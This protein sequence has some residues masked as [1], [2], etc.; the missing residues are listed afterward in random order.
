M[1]ADGMSLVLTLDL[2]KKPVAPQ[3]EE[4]KDDDV[5]VEGEGS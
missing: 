2:E 5:E 4:N 1:A 3:K